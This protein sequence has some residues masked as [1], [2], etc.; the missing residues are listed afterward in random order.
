[1]EGEGRGCLERRVETHFYP[2]FKLF[3]KYGVAVTYNLYCIAGFSLFLFFPPNNMME[4]WNSLTFTSFCLSPPF[5]F[6]LFSIPPTK[7]LHCV[8]FY[9]SSFFFCSFGCHKYAIKSP[10][11]LTNYNRLSH[12]EWNLVIE[13]VVRFRIS[14]WLVGEERFMGVWGSNQLTM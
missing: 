9:S 1:M 7:H 10:N 5:S 6:R 11:F 4:R 13:W 14:F 3:L 8:N 2:L 12:I